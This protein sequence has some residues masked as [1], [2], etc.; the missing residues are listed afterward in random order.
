[1]NENEVGKPAQVIW[2]YPEVLE[3]LSQDRPFLEI[4]EFAGG[5]SV[6]LYKPV[7]EDTQTPHT[8]DELYIV[9]AGNGTFA[10]E[11]D[12]FPFAEGDVI[13]VPAQAEH[14]FTSFS[15][16]FSTWVI[17]FGPDKTAP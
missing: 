2:R 16:N 14:R 13:F 9:A 12:E 1:M 6:E 3:K 15:D 7:G 4:A 17:F 8:R 5:L 11:G 10:I